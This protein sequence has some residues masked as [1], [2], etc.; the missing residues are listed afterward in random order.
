M[1][2]MSKN[3]KNKRFKTDEQEKVEDTFA[4]E[5][6]EE[7]SVCD[8][9]QDES[10]NENLQNEASETNDNQ[11]EKGVEAEISIPQDDELEKEKERNKSLTEMLQQLQADFDNY[12]KRNAKLEQE[13]KQRGVF[14]AVK[15]MLPAFDA[16]SVA[17]K[18]ITDENTLKGLD[19][20][21][22]ELLN[23]LDSLEIK[24]I[25]TVGM[26]FDPNLHNAVVAECVEGIPAGRVIEE[27]SAGYISP[28]GVV[29]Y[30]TVK[31]S[32]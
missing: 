3:K 9:C 25:E 32:K 19:M 8:D 18:Q 29:R 2:T 31:I 22:K 26:P 20:V 6:Q 30:A 11:C 4:E 24:P 27:Y 17:K 5:S 7:E 1:K 21:E 14:D 28:S 23:C 15:S 13:A 10:Q 12:R 16:V